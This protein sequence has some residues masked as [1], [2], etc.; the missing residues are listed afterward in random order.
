MSK[1]Q[2]HYCK[3]GSVI[4][5]DGM[6]TIIRLFRLHTL[7]LK[8]VYM[9]TRILLE[10]AALAEPL[11]GSYKVNWY[12]QLKIGEDLVIRGVVWDCWQQ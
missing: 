2:P 5:G 8:N 11:A 10:A 7:F 1:W 12:S 6:D 4:G 3:D 9:K